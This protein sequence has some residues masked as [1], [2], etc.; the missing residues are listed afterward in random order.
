MIN[1]Y[2][3]QG[4]LVARTRR[5][6]SSDIKHVICQSPTGSGKTVMFSYI[7][8]KA[9]Y[10][11][12]TTLIITDRIELLSQTGG[13]VEQFDL[14]PCYIKAGTTI[15]Q[16][17]KYVYIA[18][19]QTLRNRIK[20]TEWIEFIKNDIDLIIIDEAHVQEF[21]YLFQSGLLKD[22]IVLG[23][24]ATPI[25]A[26]KSRQ[27]GLDYERI[28]YGAPIKDLIEDEYLVNCDIYDCGKP[29]L[30][31]VNFNYMKGD[32]LETELFKRYDSPIRYKGLIKNY[33][34][35]TP[36]QKMIVFC[37]N[38]QHAIKTTKAL[39]KKGLDARF[40]VAT[41]SK[42][43][44]KK[45]MSVVEH[46]KYQQRSRLFKFYEKNFAKYSGDRKK[47]F[48]DFKDNKFKILV[49][50][51]IAT[52]GYDCPDIEVVALNRATLS[53]CLYLQMTGR[54]GR[55]SPGKTHFTMLDFGGN[56]ER[57]GAYDVH[58]NWNLWHEEGKEG[59]IAPVKECG[60]KGQNT[61]IKGDGKVKKGCRRLILAAYTICPFCGFK[62][63]KKD[64][65]KEIELQLASITDKHGISLKQKPFSDMDWDELKK[66][67]EIKKHSMAWLWRQLW[68]KGEE[69][70]IRGFARENHW[71]RGVTEMAV[72]HCHKYVN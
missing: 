23:F 47:I 11:D 43:I 6:L 2:E 12:K 14:N 20:E 19:A 17:D 25:R 22:K 31:G 49:N 39:N 38:V 52:K 34:K 63:P 27:L 54:G 50:V 55:T 48:K 51:D 26:G 69:D 28:I 44:K 40:V 59:G 65:A 41:K 67:R 37:C 8:S 16:K 61:K 9:A 10:K 30:E 71:G 21:N 60:I 15:I 68:M 66:Y 57:F 7:A 46:T 3:H 56:K 24:T 4:D 58:R 18:M 53:M 36:G 42:P 35:Y 1:L 32:Y 29:N 5:A 64:E 13:T 33:M 45:G 70:E 62:Y 72:S